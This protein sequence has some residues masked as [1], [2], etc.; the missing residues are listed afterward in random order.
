[1]I[2]FLNVFAGA[3]VGIGTLLSNSFKDKVTQEERKFYQLRILKL[4]DEATFNSLK[5]AMDGAIG[6]SP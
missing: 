3:T 4:L 6:P 1:L 2:C 5:S